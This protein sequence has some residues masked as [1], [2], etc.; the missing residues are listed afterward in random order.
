MARNT[1]C[2]LAGAT[3]KVIAGGTQRTIT[4]A[5]T[6][7][8][9]R[10][11]LRTVGITRIANVTGMDT[12]GI[13]T[14]MVVRPQARSLSVSQ[15]KGTDLDAAR[16]SGIMESIE[17]W[18]AER[19]ERPL[20]LARLAEIE[21][22]VDV[23]RLPRSSEGH[24]SHERLLWIEGWDVTTGSPVWVPHEM[25]H[26]DL[27]IPLPSGSGHFPIG[28]NGL[29][30]G[31]DLVEA[32]AHAI[33]EVVER[34]ATTLFYQLSWERQWE[35]RID[36]ES[37]ADHG[38]A[39][40]LEAFL[41]AA[42]DVAIWDA[43][44]DVGVPTYLCSI[45][46]HDPDPFHPVGVARG[47]GCHPCPAVA[48]SRALTE[49]AQSRLTRI[50]GTRDD[51]Q[52][53]EFEALRKDSS[54]DRN[55]RQ[56]T[57]PGR[58]PRRLSDSPGWSATTFEEDVRRTCDRLRAVGVPQ[59]VAVDLS[60]PVFPISVVRAIIPGLEGPSEVPGYRP[61]RRART[62]AEETGT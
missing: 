1:S 22:R 57:A 4:P 50:V 23:Y 30:S 46:D 61:G 15:G 27:T 8:R 18:H 43:T 9:V 28:S 41:R 58:P 10:P 49:A 54:I 47:A 36:P 29:A 39:T 33:F 38:C 32:L 44:S 2:G 3:P 11:F 31:N 14:V 48:L 42:V 20:R 7:A 53:E 19:I 13:P 40:L 25:V 60:Q 34:D 59:V 6:V 21:N 16:A 55:R 5:E 56:M 37:V 62:L 24:P 52:R 51:I 17:Q 26:L 35:R 45:L 12:I